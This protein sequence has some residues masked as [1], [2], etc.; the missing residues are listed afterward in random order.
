[1]SAYVISELE[2]RDAVGIETYRSI[3]AKL[4]A[5]YGGVIWSVAALQV[6]RKADRR[7]RTSSLSCFPRW[8]NCANGTRRRNMPK[9]SRCDGR[10]WTAA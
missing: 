8:K 3:A 7:Q 4:I 1:M 6:L 9:R 10:R 5:Q 2:V